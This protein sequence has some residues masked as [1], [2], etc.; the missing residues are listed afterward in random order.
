MNIPCVTRQH[1]T[2]YKIMTVNNT[3]FVVIAAAPHCDTWYNSVALHCWEYSGV[4]E[5]L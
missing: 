2:R 4:T 5:N 1:D 3:Y